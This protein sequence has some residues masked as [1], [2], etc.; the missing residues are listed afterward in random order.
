MNSVTSRRHILKFYVAIIAVSFFFSALGILLTIVFIRRSDQGLT[1]PSDYLMLLFSLGVLFM[2]VYTVVKYCKNAPKIIIDENFISFNEE[3]FSLADIRK[4]QLT[5]KRRFPYIFHYGME[6][7]II[8][9]KDGPERIIFDDMYE[10]TW[11]LK[12]FLKHVVI[13]KKRTPFPANIPDNNTKHA[14]EFYDTFKNNQ[15]S[16]L[17]GA[18]FWGLM[19]FFL[20]L[21]TKDNKPPNVAVLIFCV[22]MSA[23]FLPI[24]I[25]LM[26][27]FKVS[28]RLFVVRNH[29]L[30]WKR[31]AYLLSGI[32]EIVFETRYNMPHCLRVITK[33]F[34]SKLYPAGSLHDSTWLRLKERLESVGVKVRN[35]CV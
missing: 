20:Y 12:S 3:T 13:D 16:S 22:C 28:D 35:E 27:Y 8:Y 4:V 5:G 9:F 21:I 11:E 32:Q 6:A 33:D 19:I 15:F 34:Q 17:R 18:S 23:V 10:N 2:V 25:W 26:H 30:P 14:N 1:K 29:F 7:A 24:H 31:R